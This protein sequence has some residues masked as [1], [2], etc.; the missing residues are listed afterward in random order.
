MIFHSVMIAL[1]VVLI[2]C[3]SSVQGEPDLKGFGD[4]RN[5]R[6]AESA[7]Y[8]LFSSVMNFLNA[9]IMYARALFII[10]KAEPCS[11]YPNCTKRVVI[12]GLCPQERFWRDVRRAAGSGADGGGSRLMEVSD[13][14]FVLLLVCAFYLP[15]LFIRELR[16]QCHLMNTN[17]LFFFASLI[18]ERILLNGAAAFFVSMICQRSS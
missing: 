6:E 2:L 14:F 15:L 16:C 1:R 13:R 9:N 5:Y 17:R 18:R 12:S 8:S 3:A 4:L 11:W 7:L 10:E